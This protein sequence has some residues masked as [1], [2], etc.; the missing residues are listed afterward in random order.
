[1]VKADGMAGNGIKRKDFENRS[2]TTSI[3]EFP[4]NF[5]KSV[6]KLRARWDHGRSGMGKGPN[7]PAG[8]ARGPWD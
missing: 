2:R 5:G 7:F 8:S 6:M 4:C 1:M 3:A